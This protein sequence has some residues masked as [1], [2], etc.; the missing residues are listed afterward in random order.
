MCVREVLWVGSLGGSPRPEAVH[1][2]PSHPTRAVLHRRACAGRL[3]D[4]SSVCSTIVL[5]WVRRALLVSPTFPARGL[6]T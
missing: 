6:T 2:P 5:D 1:A 4:I 3:P